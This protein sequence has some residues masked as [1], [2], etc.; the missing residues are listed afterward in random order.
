MQREQQNKLLD[1]LFSPLSNR[2][3]PASIEERLALYKQRNELEKEGKKYK[4]IKQK[5]L[6][7]REFFTKLVIKKQPYEIY[8][9]S[10]STLPRK[11]AQGRIEFEH[12]GIYYLNREEI[13]LLT[14]E[15]FNTL[16]QSNYTTLKELIYNPL[17]IEKEL[18]L[19][20]QITS[21]S[22]DLSPIFVVEKIIDEK[23]NFELDTRCY[24]DTKERLIVL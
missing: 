22:Y 16:T 20:E 9:L 15:H 21:Q 19:R 17:S 1:E 5:F 24:E 14:L 23:L 10:Y 13:K 12:N 7:Y 3:L 2:I 18:L 6:N 11:K 4:I 8:A